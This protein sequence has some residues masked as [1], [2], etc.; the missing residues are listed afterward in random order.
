MHPDVLR[1]IQERAYERRDEPFQLSAGAWTHD[2]VDTKKAIARA[3]GLRLVA[4]AVS[5]EADEA[6]M[7]FDAVGGLTMGADPL[8]VAVALERGCGWFSIRKE[9]KG[10]GTRR[11]VEGWDVGPGTTVLAVEDVV[12]TGLSLLRAVDVLEELGATVVGAIAVVDRGGSMTTRL[13]HR[14]VPFKAL[15][16]FADLGIPAVGTGE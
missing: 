4:S 3:D 13:G 16:T 2:Y 1:L 8:A 14:G 15:V 5:A 6:G 12:T 10:H 7:Q 11:M 9:P